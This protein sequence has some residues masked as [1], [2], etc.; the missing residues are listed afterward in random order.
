ME[1]LGEVRGDQDE[2][3]PGISLRIFCQRVSRSR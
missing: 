1:G 3:I 2:D